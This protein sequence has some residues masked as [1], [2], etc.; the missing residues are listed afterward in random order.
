MREPD[1][2]ADR[3]VQAILNATLRLLGTKGLAAITHRTVAAEAGVPLGSTTYYFR[4]KRDLLV[5]TLQY[6]EAEDAARLAIIGDTFAACSTA[7]ELA[8]EIVRL[9][10][11]EAMIPDPSPIICQFELLVAAVRMP[12]LRPVGD[13]WD[14]ACAATVSRGFEAIGSTSPAVDAHTVMAN[15]YGHQTRVLRAHDP[16]A[17]IEEARTDLRRLVT[18][19]V[20]SPHKRGR[21]VASAEH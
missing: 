15:V 18:G 3:R 16:R 7:E 21:K 5:S 10:I 12:E 13:R 20:P 14:R 8:D 19:L 17:A 9:L 4:S 2:R 6:A 1:D 11:E